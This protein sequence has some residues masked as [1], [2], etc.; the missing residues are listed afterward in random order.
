MF[1][2]ADNGKSHL[3]STDSFFLVTYLC[4][5]LPWLTLVLFPSMGELRG[6]RKWGIHQVRI[7]CS[8][9]N[10]EHIKSTSFKGVLNSKLRDAEKTDLRLAGETQ[11]V[12]FA[13]MDTT[14][15]HTTTNSQRGYSS[16]TQPRSLGSRSSLFKLPAP[17]EGTKFKAKSSS[18]PLQDDGSS[19]LLRP[20][21]T[22]ASSFNKP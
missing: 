4:F 13:G 16:L 18:L 14:N 3:E 7:I 12:V 2:I 1:N 21:R 8:S 19:P 5:L 20:F 17:I 11:L 9:S 10:T 6:R 15:K 22:S